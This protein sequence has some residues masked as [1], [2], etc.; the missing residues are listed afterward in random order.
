MEVNMT[1]E[2]SGTT[3][4]SRK[5]NNQS[6]YHFHSFELALENQEKFINLW[7]SYFADVPFIEAIESSVDS[8]LAQIDAYVEATGESAK[9]RDV[10]DI[11]C[12]SSALTKLIVRAKLL[13]DSYREQQDH[14]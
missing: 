14:E 8:G 7:T 10:E 2:K 3:Q 13:L 9:V 4:E 6:G 11:I 12:R 5:P 1:K